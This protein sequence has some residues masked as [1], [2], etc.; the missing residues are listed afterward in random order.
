MMLLQ[1]NK[2]SKVILPTG[3]KLLI[4]KTKS[5]WNMKMNK[6]VERKN[7]L[8]ISKEIKALMKEKSMNIYSHSKVEV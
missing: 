8:M 2:S 5:D 6:G 4:L 1:C 7:I 3:M